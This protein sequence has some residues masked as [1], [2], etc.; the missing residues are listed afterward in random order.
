MALG[1]TEKATAARLRRYDSRRSTDPHAVS[2]GPCSGKRGTGTG[3]GL[4]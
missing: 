1:S 4:E 3:V 2:V